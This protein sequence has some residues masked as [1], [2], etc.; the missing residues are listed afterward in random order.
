[1]TTVPLS[2]RGTLYTFTTVHAAPSAFSIPYTIGFIDL[3]E[4]VRILA[5]IEPTNGLSIGDELEVFVGPISHGP[6]G[7]V[8]QGYKFRK[9]APL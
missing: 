1:M 7:S 5:Q 2:R 8:V 3:P 9:T 6:D 4:D